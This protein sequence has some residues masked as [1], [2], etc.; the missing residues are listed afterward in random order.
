MLKLMRNISKEAINR[1]KSLNFF[2]V[3][4]VMINNKG[5]NIWNMYGREGFMP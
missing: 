2:Y 1:D 4:T 3:R 5:K